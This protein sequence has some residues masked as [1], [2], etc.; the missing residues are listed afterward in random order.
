[1]SFGKVTVSN[2][3]TPLL[4]IEN[5]LF[6]RDIVQYPRHYVEDHILLGNRSI[7]TVKIGILSKDTVF[8][9]FRSSSDFPENLKSFC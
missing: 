7:P 8:E 1:M 3:P 9:R 4:P 2:D 6:C 5:S